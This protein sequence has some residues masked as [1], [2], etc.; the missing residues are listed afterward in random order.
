VPAAGAGNVLRLVG[1]RVCVTGMAE[2]V[3]LSLRIPLLFGIT[4]SLLGIR[5]AAQEPPATDTLIALSTGIQH[6]I[7]G[8]RDFDAEQFELAIARFDDVLEQDPA[9]TT[10]L[11]YRAL[12]HGGL[13]LETRL[14]KRRSRNRSLNLQRMIDLRSDPKRLAQLRTE[15][16]QA[17]AIAEN[18]DETEKRV[19]EAVVRQQ[20]SFLTL[21]DSLSDQPV[22]ALEADRAAALNLAYSQA[23]SERDQYLS[24]LDDLQALLPLN[25]SPDISVRLMEV[26]ARAN[27]ARIQEQHA[28]GIITEELPTGDED[29]TPKTMREQSAALLAEAAEILTSIDSESIDP[30]LAN[31]VRFFLGV[32]R[33]RQAVPLK[34]PDHEKSDISPERTALLL[35]AE[36]T[37]A[38]LADDT[39][40]EATWRSYASLYLGMIIPFR[41]AQTPDA[42]AR[43][44][45]LDEADRRLT[46]SVKRDLEAGG[47]ARSTIP[48]LV[49]RQRTEVIAPLRVAQSSARP[50][51]DLSLSFFAGARRDTNVVLLGERTD[52]PR[53]VSRSKDYGFSAGLSADYTLDFAER[54]TLGLQA[55]TAEIWNVDVHEFDQQLYG[56]SVALQ[57]VLFPESNG[58]GPAYFMLQYDGDYVLLGRKGFL[59]SNAIT[60]SLRL[61]WQD[62]MARSD[63][64]FSY[65][66]RDYSEPL[67]D[68]RFDRDGDYFTVG[69]AHRVK[70]LEMTSVYRSHGLT[71]WGHAGDDALAQTDP[72]FPQRYLTLSGGLSYAWDATEGDEFDRR[73]IG[74]SAGV[75]LPLPKGFLME[76]S[77]SFQ[78]EDYPQHSLVDF[79]RRA[80]QDFVQDYALAVSRTYVMS[81][82]A[83]INRT[84]PELDHTLMTMRAYVSYTVDDSNVSDRLSQAIFSYDRWIVGF[85]VGFTIN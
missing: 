31:R 83:R 24:L 42:T 62:G 17:K 76:F 14:E 4:L 60:P 6:Y 73:A 15:L 40:A 38:E 57:H 9:N 47:G 32:I 21:L 66:A 20:E 85:T 34:D 52:L 72:D 49:W 45:I 59:T 26:V 1:D 28:L 35:D 67:S 5:G 80:R 11:L 69:F 64:V 78:W 68:V 46:E 25:D 33:F 27:I 8:R 12:S 39:A 2:E 71:P 56:G 44:A 70:A 54:W 55:R 13:A 30:Q 37:M 53:D 84:T 19:A 74:V 82:G 65:E 48:D 58:V 81:K 75:D 79:H 63:V 36:E 23:A 41:A 77:A 50:R 10:A 61:Y 43:N 18:G 3:R 29:T 7:V 16:A 51:N 22:A